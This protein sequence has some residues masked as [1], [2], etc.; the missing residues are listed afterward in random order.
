[1]QAFLSLKQFESFKTRQE[2][3]NKLL[4]CYV[5]NIFIPGLSSLPKNSMLFFKLH[6][7][8]TAAVFPA[9]D[10]VIITVKKRRFL[11]KNSKRNGEK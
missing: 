4:L 10:F 2:A 8:F 7:K 5:G 6:S 3:Y 11:Q 1:M 9:L